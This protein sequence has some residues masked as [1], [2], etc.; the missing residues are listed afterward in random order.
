M[1]RAQDVI[2]RNSSSYHT[3]TALVP[4]VATSRNTVPAALL[5]NDENHGT[6]LNVNYQ[7]NLLHIDVNQCSDIGSAEDHNSEAALAP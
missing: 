5:Q 1:I 6:Q 4:L 7:R 2:K 3:G